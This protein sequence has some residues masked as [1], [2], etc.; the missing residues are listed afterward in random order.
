MGEKGSLKNLY[1]SFRIFLMNI[2]KN[3]KEK[4]NKNN[5]KK[6]V[7]KVNTKIKFSFSIV[8]TIFLGFLASLLKPIKQMP[9]IKV[10]KTNEDLDKTI[11]VVADIIK[12]VDGSKD[13]VV[14][15]KCKEKIASIK[16]IVDETPIS[17]PAISVLKDNLKSADIK[18]TDK[19]ELLKEEP[20]EEEKIK[21]VK[22][23][24]EQQ[25]K[26][27]NEKL[28]EIKEDIKEIEQKLTLSVTEEDVF[29]LK[30]ELEKLEEKFKND[31]LKDEDIKKLDQFLLLYNTEEIKKLK[32]KIEQK[33]QNLKEIKEQSLIEMD[34]NIDAKKMNDGKIEEGKQDNKVKEKKDEKK[35]EV[36][37]TIFNPFSSDL[38]LANITIN[39]QI[40]V[41]EHKVS[42]LRKIED[43]PV[44]FTKIGQMVSN[45][46]KLCINIPP[47]GFFKNRVVGTFMSTILVNNSIRSL[48][49]SIS[50]NKKDIYY[51]RMN[52]FDLFLKEQKEIEA[53]TRDILDDSMSQLNVFKNEFINKYNSYLDS[54]IAVKKMMIEIEQ[55]EEYIISKQEQYKEIN[56]T[57]KTKL[58]LKRY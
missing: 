52:K 17:I 16:K 43:K 58:K 18:A 42:M 28:T 25:I 6:I 46:F 21:E 24:K 15:K 51:L 1:K 2:K 10:I 57:I 56:Q 13:I 4:N 3:K 12:T 29:D 14:I 48:R 37:E 8:I 5:S 31:N 34:E 40:L 22:R 41:W 55:I 35:E 49:R 20:K 45:V 44:F 54:N 33:L 38:K 7:K 36:K 27:S 47:F 30:K 39:K 32:S 19:I 11:Q 9:Q 50:N 26:K 53:R 23:Q